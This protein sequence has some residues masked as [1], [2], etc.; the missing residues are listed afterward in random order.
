MPDSI[1]TVKRFAM[2]GI[3]W[4]KATKGAGW[5]LSQ[6]TVT[7]VLMEVGF[8]STLALAFGAAVTT[9]ANAVRQWVKTYKIVKTDV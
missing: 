4:L 1:Q 9:T 3:G 6:A 5:A 7:G 2:G 8:D